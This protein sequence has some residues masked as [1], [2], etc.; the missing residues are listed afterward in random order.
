MPPSFAPKERRRKRDTRPPREPMSADDIVKEIEKDYREEMRRQGLV[1]NWGQPIKKLDKKRLKQDVQRELEE[2]QEK[3][4]T[5]RRSR[6]S[7]SRSVAASVSEAIGKRIKE[8]QSKRESKEMPTSTGQESAPREIRNQSSDDKKDSRKSGRI[9]VVKL[10]APEIR[11]VKFQSENELRKYIETELNGMKHLPNFDKL[12]NNALAHINLRR[13]VGERKSLYF[14]EIRDLSKRINVPLRTTRKWITD[15]GTP[16]FYKLAESAITKSESSDLLRRLKLSR[17]GIDDISE[18]HKRLDNSYTGNYV[19]S[20]KSF[21]R[22]SEACRKYFRF[23]EL[24]SEGGIVTNIARR[25]NV[26]PLTGRNYT[27]GVFPHLLK[28]VVDVPSDAPKQGW[29][30]LPIENM[31]TRFMLEVPLKAKDWSD[32]REV[33]QQLRVAEDKLT[34]LSSKFGIHDIDSAFMYTLG[35]IISDG[36][37]SASGLSSRM[38]LAL[39]K[40]YY[41][42]LN[43]GNAVCLCLEVFGIRTEKKPD[44]PSPDNYITERGKKRR[45]TGPGFHVWESEKHPF[46]RWI[47]E[48]C[49]GL[50]ERQNKIETPL[51]AEWTLKAPRRLR[52]ALIQGI[53]DGDG[54][55]SVNSQYAALSTRIN[56]PYFGRLLRSLNIESIP[57]KKDVLIKQTE[58]IIGFAELAPFREAETRRQDLEELA[59]LVRARKSKD[60]SARLSEAEIDHALKL[61][62]QGKSYGEIT[63]LVFRDFGKSWDISTIEHA[64]K[65]RRMRQRK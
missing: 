7:L 12:L 46:L 21:N 41:W 19:R 24:L 5:K 17:N 54:Y 61:R 65:K 39:S 15:Y 44:W 59:S 57:T 63:R 20:L 8:G 47:R 60:P 42:S 3:R 35:A 11:G 22:D 64:I 14:P 36:S 32:V 9:H 43:F 31:G 23:L 48:G 55:V 4:S 26:S 56:Q 10:E 16:K 62:Q 50:D 37:L 25:A 27:E 34:L 30:W 29:K 49:L 6:R 13:M 1:D 28:R 40:K 53:A 2:E 45:I 51:D 58:S 18:I 52:T 33:L 38:T